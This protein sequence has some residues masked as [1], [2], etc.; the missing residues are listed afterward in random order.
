MHQALRTMSD[1]IIS[2]MVSQFDL[3]MSLIIN[4][5]MLYIGTAGSVIREGA[6]CHLTCPFYEQCSVSHS[7]VHAVCYVDR[8]L[9]S[10]L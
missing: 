9:C 7:L 3:F 5:I 6:I 10:W 8:M 1:H 4:T 2:L